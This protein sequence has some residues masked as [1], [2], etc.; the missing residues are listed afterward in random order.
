MDG[1]YNY[2]N[3]ISG[4]DSL[5]SDN[6]GVKQAIINGIEAKKREIQGLAEGL[7]EPLIV[8]GARGLTSFKKC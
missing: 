1:F 5:R 3:E 2:D 7:T 6:S 4:Y 8:D